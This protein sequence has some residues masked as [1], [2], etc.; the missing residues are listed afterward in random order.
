MAGGEGVSETRSAEESARVPFWASLVAYVLAV[1]GSFGAGLA[2]GLVAIIV[3]I[4]VRGMPSFDEIEALGLDPLVMIPSAAGGQLALLVVA[5]VTPLV[6]RARLREALGL[7]GAPVAAFLVAPLGALGLGPLANLLI[8]GLLAV[9]PEASLGFLESL[10]ALIADAPIV[11]LIPVVSVMPGICEELLF[12][13]L[14]QRSLGNGALAIG[15]TSV[16]FASLHV[17][18]PHVVATLPMGIYLGVLAAR[19]NSV[20]VGVFGHAV[21]NAAS[22]VAS[23]ISALDVGHGS[24]APM[25]LF[26]VPAGLAVTGLALAVVWVTTRKRETGTDAGT[27]TGT[28]TA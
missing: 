5:L 10:S 27:G 23:R 3:V 1:I 17:D 4:A 8:E 20:W 16:L 9:A 21:N 18:P 24:D 28:G 19:T 6:F 25:P 15:V 22:I 26:W 11:A 13:G 2:V 12:R 14:I 7:G